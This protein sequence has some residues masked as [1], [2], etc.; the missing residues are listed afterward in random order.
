M[1]NV[2]HQVLKTLLS[3]PSSLIATAEH[4][5]SNSSLLQLENMETWNDIKRIIPPASAAWKNMLVSVS[6]FSI[7]PVNMG[8]QSWPMLVE[9]NLENPLQGA[10][11][12]FPRER[13]GH[14]R[15]AVL[16]LPTESY[17]LCR[18]CLFYWFTDLRHSSP[19]RHLENFIFLV[20]IIH[21]QDKF[22]SVRLPLLSHVLLELP[23]EHLS[24]RAS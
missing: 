19:K 3:D 5:T 23:H 15:G 22:C 9:S 11:L 1:L 24:E 17:I 16:L 20:N 14:E 8:C 2:N 18:H 13:S 21:S 10:G 7:W 4:S 6:T 12:P